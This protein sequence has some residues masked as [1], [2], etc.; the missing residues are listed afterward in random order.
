MEDFKL[1]PEDLEFLEDGAK[2]MDLVEMEAIM[3]QADLCLLAGAIE[4]AGALPS[5][6]ILNVDY[7]L[8]PS[9]R[10]GPFS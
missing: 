1:F 2:R 5:L 9:R 10:R 8:L 4:V 7:E 3:T 6:R